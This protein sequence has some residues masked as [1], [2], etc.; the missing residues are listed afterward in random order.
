M[1]LE[2]KSV[3]LL[4]TVGKIN[5]KFRREQQVLSEEI[6]IQEGLKQDNA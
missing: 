5:C 1:M 3:K 4:D 6:H 2:V